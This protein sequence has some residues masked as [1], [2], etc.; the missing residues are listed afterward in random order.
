M[1]GP[2]VGMDCERLGVDWIDATDDQLIR[3][4]GDTKDKRER[5]LF[6]R[7]SRELE[8]M[9]DTTCPGSGPFYWRGEERP[10][11][12]VYRNPHDRLGDHG[13][14]YSA[15]ADDVEHD[16]YVREN[17]GCGLPE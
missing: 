7:C 1:I 6:R 4:F 17:P 13:S 12:P 11:A 8:R 2:M 5:R 10:P 15:M 14:R 9:T 3:A 16:C